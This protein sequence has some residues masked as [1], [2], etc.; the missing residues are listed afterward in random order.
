MLTD[1]VYNQLSVPVSS[2]WWAGRICYCSEMTD[3]HTL[4]Q[5]IDAIDEELLELV[6]RRARAAKQIGAVKRAQALPIEDREREQA[7]V[8]RM[9]TAAEMQH[10]DPDSVEAVWKILLQHAKDIQS[11]ELS[12]QNN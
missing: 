6:A 1:T 8:Q 5:E 10:L 9:R 2:V 3:I 11:E 12:S 4:R 7:L